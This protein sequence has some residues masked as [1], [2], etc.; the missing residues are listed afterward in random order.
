MTGSILQYAYDDI[1]KSYFI[2]FKLLAAMKKSLLLLTLLVLTSCS[3]DKDEP[4][5]PSTEDS[6]SFYF[7]NTLISDESKSEL[8][9][10][11]TS[12]DINIYDFVHQKRKNY[13][14]FLLE[15]VLRL[16]FNNYMD[17]ANMNNSSFLFRALDGFSDT[18]TYSQALSNGGY[19]AYEDLDISGSDN[20]ELVVNENNNNPSPF[21]VVWSDSTSQNPFGDNYPWPYQLAEIEIIE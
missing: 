16:G 2:H 6:I 11:L 5:P 21:Y 7:G 20:W 12:Y 8:I 14:A 3:K 1:L 19:V 13:R 10:G 15:D 18:A 9:A 4:D 17:S